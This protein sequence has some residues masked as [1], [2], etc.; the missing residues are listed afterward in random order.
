MINTYIIHYDK[1]TERKKYLKPLV[2]NDIWYENI[3]KE[4]ISKEQ[5]EQYYNPSPEEWTKRCTNIYANM[6]KYR[7]LKPGSIS[8]NINHML[9][10]KD[11]I[12]KDNYPYG[13]FLEDDIILHNNF[14]DKLYKIL[15]IIPAC[16]AIFI[17]G[18][19]DH[20]IAPTIKTI[21]INDEYYFLSKGTPATNCL[22]SYVLTKNIATKIY[23]YLFNYKFVLPIDFEL[24]YLFYLFKSHIIHISPMLCF[25]GSSSG[26]YQSSQTC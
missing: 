4:N 11:F 7:V 26:Y 24:N 18:G 17:G 22:C 6:P 16:D 21:K 10:W 3:N 19:F 5:I 2:I 23:D 25:E 9:A 12:E 14:Y 1:L 15:K 13:L 8:C 20:N